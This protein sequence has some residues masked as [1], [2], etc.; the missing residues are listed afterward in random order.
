MLP[1]LLKDQ[2]AVPDMAHPHHHSLSPNSCHRFPL[3]GS[4]RKQI[5]GASLPVGCRAEQGRGTYFKGACA[6]ETGIHNLDEL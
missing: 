6:Q 2:E 4:S 5:P 3:V 1:E